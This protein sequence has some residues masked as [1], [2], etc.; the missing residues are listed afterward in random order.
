[1]QKK[2]SHDWVHSERYGINK[3]SLWKSKLLLIH[4]FSKD[5]S[6]PLQWILILI[7]LLTPRQCPNG[8]FSLKHKCSLMTLLILFP[9]LVAFLDF[10][11]GSISLT[12]TISS[13]TSSGGKWVLM[14]HV[15]IKYCISPKNKFNYHWCK[16]FSSYSDSTKYNILHT[17]VLLIL[18]V[19]YGMHWL[20]LNWVNLSFRQHFSLHE[21]EL[22]LW[23]I[24]GSHAVDQIWILC[25]C[26]AEVSS[27][28]KRLTSIIAV[29][30]M[31]YT[32]N[33][34]LCLTCK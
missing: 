23:S 22:W 20:G 2:L 17:Q 12:S 10:F 16:C 24:F 27:P 3:G 32:Y 11:W 25:D 15:F 9:I 29:T 21:N 33:W 30:T 1:M 28:K 18:V 7:L 31:G 8:R 14:I 34:K 4:C 13:L 19:L 26:V 6:E 5:L